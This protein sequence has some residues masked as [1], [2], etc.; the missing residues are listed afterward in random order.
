MA[1]KLFYTVNQKDAASFKN[2]NEPVIGFVTP[3]TDEEFGYIL[4][5]G[6]QYGVSAHMLSYYAKKDEIDAL[7][8]N[9][10]VTEGE[11]TTALVDYAK[12]E[13]IPSLDGYAKTED[14][15]SLDGYA[16][17]TVDTSA[18]SFSLADG[19]KYSLMLDPNGAISIAKYIAISNVKMTLVSDVILPNVV[20]LTKY[21]G[22]T[23][24]IS[25]AITKNVNTDI[26]ATLTATNNTGNNCDVKVYAYNVIDSTGTAYVDQYGKH[27]LLAKN[28]QE[29][30]TT[31]TFNAS[32]TTGYHYPE[33]KPYSSISNAI[34]ITN[35]TVTQFGKKEFTVTATPDNS[36]YFT[37]S[38]TEVDNPSVTFSGT[39]TFPQLSKTSTVTGIV[40]MLYGTGGFNFADDANY[41]SYCATFITST[42]KATGN[43]AKT[44]TITLNAGDTLAIAV[45]SVI[46]NPTVQVF[47]ANMNLEIEGKLNSPVAKTFTAAFKD[48]NSKEQTCATEYNIYTAKGSEESEAKIYIKI[49]N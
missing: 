16:V 30:F 37:Y 19:T 40:P 45:P 32:D 8:P 21:L 25:M 41:G 49:T 43:S 31:F 1:N 20:T 13:D 33:T 3:N 12:T 2:S 15:P 29:A 11:L 22:N 36:Y 4:V 46:T 5:S 26:T 6:K 39:A 23:Y 9:D 17:K 24:S 35:A 18:N 14:I 38:V 27:V 10:I 44:S 7:I 42:S 47:D 28:V 48:S 34:N